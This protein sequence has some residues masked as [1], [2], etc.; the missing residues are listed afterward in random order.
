MTAIALEEIINLDGA[1][2]VDENNADDVRFFD[3]ITSSDGP[4]LGLKDISDAPPHVYKS[5]TLMIGRR[6]IEGVQAIRDYYQA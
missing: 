2:F 6:V 1:M 3:Q 5:P 4:F